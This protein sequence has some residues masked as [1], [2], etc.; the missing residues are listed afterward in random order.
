MPEGI[1]VFSS[2]EMYFPGLRVCGANNGSP[3]TSI[4]VHFPFFS[5]ASLAKLYAQKDTFRPAEK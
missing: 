1:T 4:V 2:E 5:N 3:H